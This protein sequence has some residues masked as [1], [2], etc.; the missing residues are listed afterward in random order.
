MKLQEKALWQNIKSGNFLPVYLIVGDENYL[1]QKYANLLADSVVPAG[2]EAFN[3]HKLK[4]EDTTPEEI[5]D[6]VLAL[7]AMCE[8]T[9]VLVHDYDF[10][11]AKEDEKEFLISLL[12]DLPD[13]CVLIFWQDTKGFST[14]TKLSKQI[15]E[16]CTNNGALCNLDKREQGDLARFVV[17]ECKKR[18]REMSID[19]AYYLVSS[20]GDDMANLLNEIE[21]LCS[22]ASAGITVSDIDAICVKSVE[23]TAFQ[24]IDALLINDFDGAFSALKVL[25]E[26]RTEPTMILGALV[27]TF[28][29]MYRVKLALES[30]HKLADLKA[31]YPVA[32]KSDFKLRNAMNRAKKYSLSSLSLSLEILGRA[33]FKLK[34]SFDD[35]QVVLEKLL[36]E[37]AKARMSR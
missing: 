17:N 2:L 23:A 7:P 22:F 16:L 24:M 29:D 34:S 20:V 4:G 5:A 14:K 6:C 13:T 32:Y 28:V 37:L 27:S 9:C 10:D 30:G 1:K 36:I 33:D 15:M 26:Q 12:S 11:N 35:N 31:A 3:V 8:R 18:D 25:M 21:K 19:A